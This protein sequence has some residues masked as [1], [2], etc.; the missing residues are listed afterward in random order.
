MSSSKNKNES[1][2]PVMIALL[3][4]FKQNQQWKQAG[5]EPMYEKL[6]VQHVKH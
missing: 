2:S 3:Y 1:A 5:F 6:Y 4:F